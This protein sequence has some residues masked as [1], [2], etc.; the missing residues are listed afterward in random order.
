MDC[1]DWAFGAT[2]TTGHCD[3]TIQERV[4]RM[5]GLEAQRRPKIVRRGIDRLAA[6]DG[7]HHVWRPVT[8]A[9]RFHPDQ[10]TVVGPEGGAKVQ[11]EDSVC[12]E[13]LPIGASAW[14][15]PSAKSRALEVS[16]H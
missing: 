13:K 8:E 12:S 9:E 3:E 1:I 7:R 2:I 10:P 16:A 14:Q 11:L 6:S 5:S 4:S 15:D